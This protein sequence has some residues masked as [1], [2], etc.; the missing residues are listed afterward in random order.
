MK[1]FTFLVC[2]VSTMACFSLQTPDIPSKTNTLLTE[3]QNT[4][5][6]GLWH[7]LLQKHVSNQGKVNYKGFIKDDKKLHDYINQLGKNTPQPE[8]SCEEKLAYWINAYNALTIDL[9][10]RNYPIESIKD[11]KH[12]WKQKL[13]T[14]GGDTYNLHDIEHKILRKMDEPRIHFA[15][16]CAAVSCPKLQNSAFTASKLELQLNQAA[17]D[18]LNDSTKNSISE[19]DLELSKIFQWFTNDFKQSG[20]LIDFIN[21]YTTVP[22]SAKAKIQFKSYIWKLNE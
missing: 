22:I 2:L 11:I 3:N 8:W 12:P 4:F 16:V 19:N 1:W 7:D 5:D 6:H 14:L 13:W 15:I 17:T 20:T 9:I 21:Q 18:F 10:I